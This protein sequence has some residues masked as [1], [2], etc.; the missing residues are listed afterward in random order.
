[1]PAIAVLRIRAR[2]RED[3]LVDVRLV[4]VMQVPV[5]QI[6]DVRLVENRDVSASG[7]MRVPVLI[8]RFVVCHRVPHFGRDR[9]ARDGPWPSNQLETS[10]RVYILPQ[11][12]APR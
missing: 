11:H 4:D 3:V 1:M 5:V 8:V 12:S 9:A 7:R 2:D 10:I 6:V